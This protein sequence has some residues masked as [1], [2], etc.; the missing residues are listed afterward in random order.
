[1]PDYPAAII[2]LAAEAVERELM[3]GIDY[4]EHLD[5]EEA[6]ARAVLDAVAAD[7]GNAVAAKILAH[8]EAS[9]PSVRV[10]LRGDAAMKR[11]MRR[12]H[13]ET[14]ARI[15]SRA[16]LTEEDTLRQ[17]AEALARGDYVTCP[18]PEDER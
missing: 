12:L 8:M 13:F 3:S 15:A 6:I 9:G 16:F 17:V 18:A 1:V 5:S 7:L 14:A 4:S 2:R 10:K 11:H